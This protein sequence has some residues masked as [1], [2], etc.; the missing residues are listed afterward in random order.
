M[1]KPRSKQTKNSKL[2]TQYELGGILASTGSGAATGASIGGPWGGVIGGAVGL[3]SGI[4]QSNAQDK[5]LAQKK[6]LELQQSQQQQYMAN[7]APQQ[8]YQPTFAYG[9]IKKYPDGGTKGDDP[10]ATTVGTAPDPYHDLLS[11]ARQDILKGGID[12]P[13]LYE[14][15][16]AAS[17][18]YTALKGGD[19]YGP[20]NPYTQRFKVNYNNRYP[21]HAYDV[22]AAGLVP[23]KGN[24]PWTNIPASAVDTTGKVQYID[25]TNPKKY[26]GHNTYDLNQSTIKDKPTGKH[27]AKG[28]LIENTDF[29]QPTNP[30]KTTIKPYQVANSDYANSELEDGE[31]YRTPNGDMNVVDG[32][33][34]AQG[35]EQFNLPENTEILGKNISS[36]GK[37]YKVEGEKIAKEYEK[38]RKMLEKRPTTIVKKSAQMMMDKLQGKYTNLMNEQEAN[39]VQDNNQEFAKG[40]VKRYDEGDRT[41]LPYMQAIQMNQLPIQEQVD[42]II[43]YQRSLDTPD[44]I[45]PIAAKPLNTEPVHNVAAMQ[46]DLGTS[47]QAGTPT[48]WGNVA[49]KVGTYAPIA[50]NLLQGLTGSAKQIDPNRY[51]NPYEGQVS[52]LMANRKYDTAP[53]LE[54]N[55]VAMANYYSNLRGAAPSQAQYLAGMQ[56]GQIAQ[57]RA[58][59]DVYGRASNIY[60]QYRGE[61]AST[62][63]GLGQQRAATLMQTDDIN[64][65]ARAVQSNYLPTALSQWQQAAQVNKQMQGQQSNDAI[66]QQILQGMF[67]NY[68]FNFTNPQ[69][70]R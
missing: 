22:N 37:P 56:S 65:R 51:R 30:V 13:M 28:G 45:Q 24:T 35:G 16:N 19:A 54:A 42:P 39:K 48:D 68:G 33:T 11:G 66:R 21:E 50:Y 44:Y 23:I 59:A 70:T 18:Y 62:L 47:Y 12:N 4:M 2:Q 43:K 8:Q 9:G 14:D 29:N 32:K 64:A 6:Q 26:T 27:Y 41:N 38:Y 58:N 20:N 49:N 5:A 7:L 46:R 53:E 40:G 25:Y 57:Q 15:E 17:R 52:Q 1:N 63:S 69:M 31:P 67:K 61:E 36:T 55:K 3:A 10:L 34:H 60:N